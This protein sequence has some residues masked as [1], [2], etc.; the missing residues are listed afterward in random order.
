MN[1][2]FGH[3]LFQILLQNIEHKSVMLEVHLQQKIIA[4]G[5]TSCLH[6]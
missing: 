2:Q 1:S 4:A 3:G 6:Q 5:L